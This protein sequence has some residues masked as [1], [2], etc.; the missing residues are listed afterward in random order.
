M[1]LALNILLWVMAGVL[2]VPVAIV[3]AEVFAALLPQ[4]RRKPEGASPRPRIGVIIPAHNEGAG[5]VRTLE[6]IKPQLIAGDRLIVVADNCSDDTANVARSFN[7]EVIERTD[8]TNRGKGY[9]L[10]F[11]VKHLAATGEPDI[12]VILDADVTLRDGAIEKLVRQ[13]DRTGCPAQGVYL[14]SEPPSAGGK[15]IVSHLAFVVRNHVRPLGLSRL[16]GPCPL[17][18]AGMAFPWKILKEAP[19]ATGNIVEDI[20]LALDLAVEG[21]APR[22][23]PDAFIDGQLPKSDAAASKQRRR[24]EHGHLR[25]ILTQVPRTM[26]SG[27]FRG[28][29]GAILLA[30]DILV[31]PLSL[32]VFLIL[33]AIVIAWPVAVFA[34]ASIWPAMALTIGLVA[35]VLSLVLAW[36]RFSQHDRS[37]V[38]LLSAPAYMLRKLPMYFAFFSRGG[39]KTWVR[40][41]RDTPGK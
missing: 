38:P 13:A 6:S 37:I 4:L 24:W 25:T 29:L 23:C 40:T 39:E 2:L 11:G 17:F 28:R 41:D 9:A 32:L 14:L 3:C 20:A 19:L 16:G 18:G 31:P 30:L 15:D 5:I 1:T 27:L 7:A 36:T 8:A 12:G 34:H 22:L 35:L 33:I 10:D 21:R 26:I